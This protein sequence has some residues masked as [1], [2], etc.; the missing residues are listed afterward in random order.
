MQRGL[1]LPL[2]RWNRRRRSFTGTFSNQAGGQTMRARP[3]QR[4][5]RLIVTIVAINITF[6]GV[7]DVGRA[8]AQSAEAEK[9]FNDGNRL[10]ATEKLA[11]ACAAFEASNRAEP[12]AGTLIR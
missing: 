11:E 7:F 4:C 9:L 12:R 5:R 6:D 10:M 8:Y 1:T 2:R 3:N